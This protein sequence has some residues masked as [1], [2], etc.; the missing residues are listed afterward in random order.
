MNPTAVQSIAR[1]LIASM[2]TVIVGKDEQLATVTAGFLARVTRRGHPRRQRRPGRLRAARCSH[3]D[4]LRVGDPGWAQR[5]VRSRRVADRVWRMERCE[6]V[7]RSARPRARGIL[8]GA[9][10]AVQCDSMAPPTGTRRPGPAQA[11]QDVPVRGGWS[12]ADQI[13]RRIARSFAAIADLE[14][15]KP[16]ETPAEVAR[17]VGGRTDPTGAAAVLAGYLRARYS[18]EQVEDATADRVEQAAQ[19]VT[20]AARQLDEDGSG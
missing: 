14:A 17:S 10:Q 5:P 18:P 6:N 2:A 8:C 7:A 9:A 1:R 20:E 3:R 12:P 13:E 4:H 19:R 11:M 16:G 15:P